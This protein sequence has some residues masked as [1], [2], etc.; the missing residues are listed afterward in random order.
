MAYKNIVRMHDSTMSLT[1]QALPNATDSD[2]SAI[3][4]GHST[5]GRLMIQVVAN[6]AISIADT[7]AL[8]L[9]ALFGATSSPTDQLDGAVM[10]SVTASGSAKTW[11]AG[12]TIAEMVIPPDISDT[13]KYVKVKATTTA[14]ESSEKIDIFVVML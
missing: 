13:Y 2:Y 8:T 10:M 7:K 3:Y 1:A 4:F 5:S 12:D 9:V 14:N 6:T 11:A